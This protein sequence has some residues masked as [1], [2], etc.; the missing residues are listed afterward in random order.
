[1]MAT[2]E[3][4]LLCSSSSE[5]L[6]PIYTGFAELARRG[7]IDLQA[8]RLEG[9]SGY[10]YSLP[11]LRVLVNGQFLLLYDMLDIS[12]IPS[13][14]EPDE[15]DYYFKRSYSLD[16]VRSLQL[17]RKVYPLRLAYPVF[18]RHD[19]YFCR[20]LWSRNLRD[21][22]VQFVKGQRLLS[23]L[24]NVQ[25]SIYTS[26]IDAYEQPPIPVQEPKVI[27]MTQVWWV[28]ENT[29]DEFT[30]ERRYINVMRASCIRLLRKEFGQNFIGGLKPTAYA[31]EHFG[32]CLLED[33]RAAEKR[34][35]LQA[36]HRAHIGVATMGLYGSIGFKVGEYVAASKAIVTEKITQV[37]PGDF[38]A[39]K[40]YLEF[41]TPEECVERVREL[42]DD[43][44]RLAGMMRENSSYYAR[45]LRPDAMIMNTLERVVQQADT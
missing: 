14:V 34:N 19:F 12:T 40:N 32:D 22:I 18:S 2:I 1:M 6:Y 35:Y 23:K 43:K 31:R 15:V 20:A 10:K 42:A 38:R 37:V 17:E 4:L 11:L 28:N 13:W 7:L 30:E 3:C 26:S 29:R 21:F 25:T 36:M 8:R 9:Y 24:L 5:R 27:F 44:T 39:D 45:Y 33:G 16:Y 41:E